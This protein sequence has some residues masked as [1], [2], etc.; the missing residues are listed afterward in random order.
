[1]RFSSHFDYSLAIVK[2]YDGKI[3]LAHHLKQYFAAHKKHGSADRKWITHACYAYY[4]LG[5]ALKGH[6]PEDRLKIALLLQEE[7]VTAPTF[8][9]EEIF[10]W[11]EELSADI[12]YP[13]FCRS[14]LRQPDLFLRIR[15]GHQEQV[16]QKLSGTPAEFIEPFTIRLPNGFKTESLFTIDR[17][18]VVQDYSSQRLAPFLQMA[19]RLTGATPDSPG[20]TS[21]PLSVW[22][23]CAASGGKSL[24]AYDLNRNAKPL[25]LTVSD[26]REPILHNLDRR[27]RNAG[28]GD[29]RSLVIDLTGPDTLPPGN[30]DLIIADVPCTGSGTWSRTPEALYFFDQGRIG[31]YHDVQKKIAGHILPRLNK[32]GRLVYSTCSVFKKENEEMAVFIEQKLGARLEKMEM[33]CGYTERADSMFAAQFTV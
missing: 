16:R 30:F 1:M 10:P 31:E 32:G 12:D 22:D 2:G 24:L 26:K 23:A 11:K 13:A 5:H 3:P 28:I 4:R 27:F 21:S 20:L 17:E 19:P 29:Y 33:I 7:A 18:V 25:K 14:F 6:S 8:A 15:P 9:V